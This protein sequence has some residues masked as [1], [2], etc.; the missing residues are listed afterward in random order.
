MIGGPDG[1]ARAVLWPSQRLPRTHGRRV[2]D[3]PMTLQFPGRSTRRGLKTTSNVANMHGEAQHAHGSGAHR[4][5]AVPP[6][7]QYSPGGGR[8][9]GAPK[10]N[11][12]PRTQPGSGCLTCIRGSGFSAG[13]YKLQVLFQ[14]AVRVGR[15]V[16]LK[17][18]AKGA[19]SG[20]AARTKC[21]GLKPC[22]DASKILWMCTGLDVGAE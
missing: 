21:I 15:G 6:Q 7:A 22:R 14:A 5:G 10:V 11:K 18:R 2:C 16:G 9:G 19:K 13:A 20:G 3:A 8:R 4:P 17:S 1:V 12:S